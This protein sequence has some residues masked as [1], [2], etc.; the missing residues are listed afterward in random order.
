MTHRRAVNVHPKTGLDDADFVEAAIAAL[1]HAD[2]NVRQKAESVLDDIGYVSSK[3]LS[4]LFTPVERNTWQSFWQ[5]KTR[6]LSDLD[7]AYL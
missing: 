3:A 1:S 6:R 2:K 4:V 5:R 7:R